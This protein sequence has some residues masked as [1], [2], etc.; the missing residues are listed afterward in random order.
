MR[1]DKKE[2]Y[3]TSDEHQVKSRKTKTKLKREDQLSALRDILETDG[4][5]EFF[6]R[7]LARC[8]LYETSFTG[9]SQTFFN[10]GKREIGLWVLSEIVAA[11]P[12]AYANMMLK[13]EEEFLK[14]G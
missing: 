3:D 6:R 9:N 13:N 10:E 14:N 5:K 7:L 1:E 12:K 4:G 11:D 8:K 2:T